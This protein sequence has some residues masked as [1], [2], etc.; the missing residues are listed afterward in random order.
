MARAYRIKELHTDSGEFTIWFPVSN[1]EFRD[2]IPLDENDEVL[3]GDALDEWVEESYGTVL[4]QVA[5]R[6][7][8]IENL[9]PEVGRPRNT[10]GRP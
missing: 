10:R 2:A 7:A 9:R 4:D 6:R 3:Q 5:I 8:K 1:E